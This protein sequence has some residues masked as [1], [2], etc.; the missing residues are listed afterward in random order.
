MKIYKKDVEKFLRKIGFY[1]LGPILINRKSKKI[2]FETQSAMSFDMLS[3]LSERFKTSRIDINDY[4][5]RSGC[6]T[7]DY[8]A[9]EYVHIDIYDYEW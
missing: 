1:S 5:S 3:K 4:G 8:G 7:C 2:T 6:P 9:E